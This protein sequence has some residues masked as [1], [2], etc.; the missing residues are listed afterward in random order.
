MRNNAVKRLAMSALFLLAGMPFLLAQ[1]QIKV[2]G[3][4]TDDLK[5]SM[6]GVSVFEKGTTNGVITDLDGNYM[7]SVKE[8]AVI[9]YSYIGYVTQEKKA[10][11]GVMNVTLKEDTK[12]L[13]E[14][15][16]VG[17]GVQKKSSVTGAISQVKTEDM[18][19]RTISNA[20]AALQGKTAGVQVIQTS[21]APGS[22]PTVRVRGYS[23]N[24]SSNPLYVVDGV[25]LSDIS[26]IDPNDIASM[27]VLK[28]AASA[29]IYG[30][31]AGNGVVLITTKKGKS[32]QGKITYDFQFSSQSLA[33]V[34]KMLSAEQYI[35]YMVEANTF[36]EDYLLQNWDG[37]TNTAWTDVAFENSRMQKHNIAFTN[38][39]DRGNYYLSLTYLDDNG[40][41]KGNA[42]TYKRLTATINSEY[43]IKPWL[44]VGTTNQI[45]KYNV[46]SVS[47]NN[48]YGSLLTSILQLDPLTP[49]TYTYENLPTHMLTALNSGKHLLQDDNGNYYAVSK[50]FAGEQYHPMIMRDNNI[51]KNSGFNVNGSVY[52]DF[53][54]FKGFTFTSRFGYRLSGTRSSTTDLPFYGNATQSRDYVGQSNTSSTT[55]YYQWENFA[56]YMKTFGQH[57]VT[58]MVGMSYQ[59]ST[60]DYVNGSLSPNEED[61]LKK[62]DPLFYYLNYASASAIKGV[63]GE[64]TR[65]AKLSYF[66]RVGYEFAGRY[67]L[68]AS[69]RAD[70]ADLSLLPATNRWG[71]FPAVS[72]G[73]TVSEEKFFA[74][75]KDHVSSLKLRASW[76]QNG[77]LAALS[78][79]AYSTD[80]AL[81]GLYPFV[82]GNSY[83]TSAA[84]STMGND[85]LKWE[86]SEQINVGIDA[87]FLNDRLTFSMDYFDKKTKDLLVS[88][89]TPSLIIGGSTSP[90]NAGNVSNKGWEF[91]LGW[92]DRI[93]SFNYGVRANLA[94]LKNKVTYIDPSITRLS[95]V[96]FHTSTITYFEE[97]YPVYYFRGYKFKGVDPTTGDPTFYDLDE[98]GDLNDGDLAYIGDAIPDFTYGITL[99]AGWKGFDLTV[100]GTGSQG[101]DIFNCINR[102]DFAASNKMKEVFYDN[103]WTASNPN[104]SVPRAGA[105]N[106]DK[107]QISDALV[108]DGSFFKIK[109]IQLG[110]T[111]PKNWMKKLCVGN[112]RIYGSLDDFFTFTKYPGFDP[113]AAANSTSGMGIDKGSYP[114]SKKVVLGF[115][116]EF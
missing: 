28:D 77:S 19:N 113:E 46:R 35:D 115:K 42:D 79:Y 65:S 102:P 11:P 96:N 62:N 31:E 44:K 100:F 1:N 84:P 61:A 90:M 27:E 48:E 13:D 72:V 7:L 107:Y 109:Q 41:V 66:G 108:Y 49:D 74:P 24:V 55:I 57:T 18:Q 83:I 92:R 87:R 69:L 91:E 64:K 12:T 76:G 58:A 39:S 60:Y 104:G 21:A 2:S 98:S 82:M 81:G 25:R 36:T 93:G 34:P 29:A 40:I 15:V 38:G 17:Y 85:E 89:T 112:L 80:M 4:V 73:W 45:E 8:G 68:Q 32:G 50:F 63:G 52:A 3:K 9:V 16:V 14:V 22:S 97:G 88:G 111:F 99:T 95:G 103:R 116:I 71:Y 51:G 37:V 101:N 33:R 105:T 26:G 86:T 94:T 54:P 30:A 5:E 10:V 75:L 53:K 59:E 106:M 20:P 47:T 78:G 70:A 6:I 114:C 43:E 56:N 67:L 110:Y 23:S